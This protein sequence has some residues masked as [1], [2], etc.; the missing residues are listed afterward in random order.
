GGWSGG[1][2]ESFQAGDLA[3]KLV[4]YHGDNRQCA[5]WGWNGAWLH[6]DFRFWNL[7]EYLP[8]IRVPTLVIQGE[9]DEY[10]TLK[11]VEAIQRQAGGPVEVRLLPRCGHSPHRDRPAE[12]LAE[13][14]RFAS[15]GE[16]GRP[17]VEKAAA[18]KAGGFHEHHDAGLSSVRRL[19]LPPWT[20]G[21][22]TQ[23]GS[24]VRARRESAG[25]LLGGCRSRRAPCCGAASIG[26]STRRSR[27]HVRLE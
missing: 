19:H 22:L 8:G 26:R 21:L 5:F 25:D 10:G 7:E 2:R 11:Q 6:P 12:G 3:A 24:D 9:D 17:R 4:R 20:R 1:A 23:P 15:A 18:A 27:G 13:M 14:A 16:I